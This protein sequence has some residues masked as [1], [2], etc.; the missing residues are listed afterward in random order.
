MALL[1]AFPF[2]E[3]T[4]G[5]GRQGPFFSCAFGRCAAEGAHS[6]ARGTEMQKYA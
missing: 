6:V 4:N 2:F 1:G 3:D 5:G